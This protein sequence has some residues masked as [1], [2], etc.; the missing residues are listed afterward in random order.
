MTLYRKYRPTNFSEVVGREAIKKILTEELRTGNIAHAYLFSGTRGTGKT[1][2]ARILAKSLNCEKRDKETSEPCN[3]C[4]S[5][6]AINKGNS[7]DLVEIDAASNR[8]IEEIRELREHVKYVPANAPYKV[9]II[10]EVHMLTP[11]A[12]NALLKTLEEPPEHVIFILATTELH[13]IP[14]TIFS[15]C[16]HFSFGKLNLAEITERLNFII[17]QEKA[18]ID[19]NVIQDIARRSGGALRDAESLLGQIL[20]I[21]KDNITQEDASLFLPKVGFSKTIAWLGYIIQ[22]DATNSL[23]S[24]SDLED[25]GVNLI[26]FLQEA[27]EVSRQLVLFSATNDQERLSL[28]FSPDEITEVKDL[29]AKTNANNLRKIVIELLRASQ[30]M[31]LS[32]DLPILAIELAVVEL[33]G[34]DELIRHPELQAKDLVNQPE[35]KKELPKTKIESKPVDSVQPAEL[36]SKSP[37]QIPE[38]KLNPV[39]TQASHSLEE[40]LDGWG[41]VLTK[42]KDKSQALNF[43]LGVAQPVAVNGATLELGFKY[44]LQQEKVA[45]IKN[46]DIVETIIKEVYGTD[47]RIEP[48]VREDIAAKKPENADPESSAKED[49]LVKAALEIFEGAEILN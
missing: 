42:A 4:S 49:E 39:S 7:N 21:G 48:T 18:S 20:S 37:S 47:Y 22:N 41:E 5:C 6:E 2:I 30:D 23:K 24:L 1:T 15:R 9:Y 31:K 33:C 32:P 46:R 11:E 36:I 45:E 43:V 44:R 26:F 40:I 27:L 38:Q 25:E 3:K 28:Y 14:E 29:C 13:K 35:P 16:Q 8:R 10:D 34:N 17:K 12:F 19:D